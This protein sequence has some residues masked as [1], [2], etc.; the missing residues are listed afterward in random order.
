[1]NNWEW[2]FRQS[3]VNDGFYD[4]DRLSVQNWDWPRQTWF[5]ARLEYHRTTHGK[6]V[7]DGATDNVSVQRRGRQRAA[8][9]H[10]FQ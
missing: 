4:G 10:P 6:H 5:Q 1:M 9:E 2:I 7:V 8:I 3:K